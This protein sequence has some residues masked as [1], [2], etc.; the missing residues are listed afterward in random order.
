MIEI[1]KN[2]AQY[3]LPIMIKG[4][5]DFFRGWGVRISEYSEMLR[6]F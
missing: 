6:L 2:D 1:L 3:K 4:T 5:A